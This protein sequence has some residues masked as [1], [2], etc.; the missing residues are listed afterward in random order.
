VRFSLRVGVSICIALASVTGIANTGR[1][2][3]CLP[4]L[5]DQGTRLHERGA[6]AVYW[7]GLLLRQHEVCWRI[8]T[9]DDEVR[10]FAVGNSAVFGYPLL[11]SETFSAALNARFAATGVPAHVFNLGFVTTYQLKDA[12]IVREALAYAPRVI[13]YALTLTEFMHIAPTPYPIDVEFFRANAPATLRFAAERPPGLAEPLD[14]YRVFL[15]GPWEFLR[16]LHLDQIGALVHAAV[17]RGA[18]AVRQ[19]WFPEYAGK[20]PPLDAR[21]T[22]YDCDKTKRDALSAYYEWQQWNIL[23]FLQQLRDTL[24]IDIVIVN[25]PVAHEPVDDCY[26]VRY[27]AALVQQYNQWLAEQAQRRA[28]A[29]VDVHDLLPSDAFVDSLHVTASGHQAIAEHLAPM[30]EA[31][32]ARAGTS[33]GSGQATDGLDVR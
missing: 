10:I 25:W 2:R 18:D 17:R 22:T 20:S 14:R 32:V 8:P 7:L 30:L 27:P 26:N 13:V 28:F 31:R 33:K 19:H 15:D 24:G 4:P 21:Q 9:R 1:A 23:D 3:V 5:F 6:P 29:Y 12:L 11:P 16:A